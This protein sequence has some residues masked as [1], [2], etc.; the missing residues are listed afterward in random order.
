MSE[1]YFTEDIASCVFHAESSLYYGLS[2]T[3]YQTFSRQWFS[4]VNCYQS[5]SLGTETL[6]M[7][8]NEGCKYFTRSS[9]W[10]V[11]EETS[12]LFNTEHLLQFDCTDTKAYITDCPAAC[13][14]Y[15]NIS[16]SICRQGGC[17]WRG[18]GC[19][20]DCYEYVDLQVDRQNSDATQVD[21][22]YDSTLQCQD[23]C[24]QL[25]DCVGYEF[26]TSITS[27]PN[28]FI[29]INGRIISYVVASNDDLAYHVCMQ[30]ALPTPAPTTTSE[31]TQIQTL[32]STTVNQ[33][34]CLLSY[35]TWERGDCLYCS[36][37]EGREVVNRQNAAYEGFG[38][39]DYESCEQT[40]FGDADCKMFEYN[41]VGKQC[42]YFTNNRETRDSTNTLSGYCRVNSPCISTGLDYGSG[43]VIDT[44]TNSEGEGNTS[45]DGIE[46]SATIII[47]V[48]V[49]CCILITACVLLLYKQRNELSSDE[50]I[51]LKR[52]PNREGGRTTGREVKTTRGKRTPRGGTR[53]PDDEEDSDSYFGTAPSNKFLDSIKKRNEVDLTPQDND[54]QMS[55]VFTQIEAEMEAEENPP[56]TQ[57]QNIPVMKRMDQ[58]VRN[59]HAERSASSR[60]RPVGDQST[61]RSTSRDVHR[62]PGRM[63]RTSQSPYTG[64]TISTNSYDDD[65]TYRASFDMIQLEKEKNQ[66]GKRGAKLSTH[67]DTTSPATGRLPVH[68]DRFKAWHE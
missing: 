50:T 42:Y 39:D 53:N 61:A 8:L 64:T 66:Y 35:C 20:P 37:C 1:L 55:L 60:S 11:P 65:S 36:I 54:K 7:H 5:D 26:S 33:D 43:S 17:S 34:V 67:V 3:K 14:S 28:C 4:T 47:F 63:Y 62:M 46:V 57:S 44:R 31:N 45:N 40:C 27:G 9:D 13:D 41:P 58:F 24:L 23:Q 15:T 18:S 29:Y 2:C 21:Y 32:C 10:N 6:S 30:Q 51:A 12:G 52:Y 56:T 38:F 22:T 49:F 68:Q 59:A 16:L 25:S 19:V 48:A